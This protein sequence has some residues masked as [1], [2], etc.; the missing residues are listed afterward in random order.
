MSQ[1][2][3][4]GRGGPG[5]GFDRGR[6][7]GGDRGSSSPH[8]GGDRGGSPYRGGG[9]GGS[10][11]RGGAPGSNAPLIY[12]AG[13]PVQLDPNAVSLPNQVIQ[14]I[15]GAQPGPERPAR[16]GYGTAGRVIAL[17]ANFFSLECQL[18]II[19][20]YVVQIEPEPKSQKARVKRRVLA[21]FE[22]TAL[23][24]P[25]LNEIAH[26]GAQRLVA[27]RRLPEPLQGTVAFYEEG[28]QRPPS[29]ADQYTVEVTFSKELYT[30]PMK[31]FLGGDVANVNKVD[32]VDP[33]I[34]ALNLVMQREAAQQGFRFGK[35]RYFFND[36]RKAQIGTRLWALMGFYSSV[37]PG[38]KLL[39]VNVNVCMSAFYEPGKLSDALRA[40]GYASFNAVPREFL[41]KVKV[42]TRYLGYKRVMTI[43]RVANLSASRQSFSSA[44]FGGQTSI[45]DYY[46]KKYNI[47]L[48]HPDDLPLIDVGGPGKP[49]YIP[50]ELCD[51][52][53]G[54]PHLGKLGPRETSDMLKVA[55]RKP[56]ANAQLIVE[57]GLQR[58]GYSPSTPGLNA[59]RLRLSTQMTVVPG[60]ELAPP[61]VT[62]GKGA[63]RVQNGSWNILDVKFHH[64]G[65]MP[66]WKVLVVRDGVAEFGFN[67]PNDPRLIGLIKAFANKCSDIGRVRALESISRTMERFGDPKGISLILVLLQRRDD[68]IYP[69]IKR[70]CAVKFGVRSQCMLLE[71]ALLER[72]QDQYLSNV[73]L[74]VNVKL[75][76]VNHR[77]GGD[78]LS[79]LTREPTMLV[80]IDV[81]HPGPSS[82]TGTPSIAGVVASVD[83]DFVQFPASL[84]LQ[85]S[86]QEGIAE[87]ADM[88]IERL[89]AFRRRSNVLPKRVIVFRDGVSE[90]Q[91]DK[92]IREELPQIFE[93]FK[94]IDAKNPRYH[95]TLSILICGK[96]HHARFYPT[97]S[98]HADKNGNTR[99]GTVVD[100]GVTSVVDFDFYLQAHAG[101]QGTVKPTHYIVIYDE[102]SLTADAVQQGVHSASYLYARATKAVSLVPPAY[103]A[104]IVC[105]QA[106][107]WIHGFLNLGGGSDTASSAE[108]GG[109]GGGGGGGTGSTGSTAMNRARDAAEQRV[110]D[111]A[112]RMWGN[113]LHTNLQDV[114]FYL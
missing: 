75:G 98:E 9:G 91:Y 21:L 45:A 81:T 78:A 79:W 106:R 15:K 102:S 113:G 18:D 12:N 82:V 40:F 48:Q 72:G 8:R 65:K 36:D 51:I 68:Y 7:R 88:I 97:D 19:Y 114:M 25:F 44:E 39:M 87:L 11:F 53:P 74:K 60:R 111:A 83:K 112:K 63:P 77:L 108:G 46:L 86:K 5:G 50:A 101:L 31:Q 70:L 89:Q 20:E 28:E 56:G 10:G 105:E 94:R 110:F 2:R 1:P 76:G 69:G 100:R 84:R 30:A 58:L 38:N 32:E 33:V 26:D 55:S 35:N 96:R 6:G 43:Q 47:R 109:G 34:S 107:F 29:N 37:R 42:S 99:P 54:E 57:R 71:K 67:G 80:G 92:V 52:E 22:Q 3:G 4:R 24:K 104:D 64:G 49:T 103:Y 59:F 62:Y 13:Q 23:I 17:R 93:A 41:R 61:S 90:G 85:K 27:A 14:T 73:T 16:P 66:N 95:P